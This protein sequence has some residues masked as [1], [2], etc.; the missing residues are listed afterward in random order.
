MKNLRTRRGFSLIELAIAL[1]ILVSVSSVAYLILSDGASDTADVGENYA[2]NYQGAI[3]QEVNTGS[4]LP[5]DW[6]CADKENKAFTL[7]DAATASWDGTYIFRCVD[8]GAG[9]REGATTF[10]GWAAGAR[11]DAPTGPWERAF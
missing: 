11:T 5:T 4:A 8:D 2:T 3:G 9:G 10:Y 1:A 7:K 6:A